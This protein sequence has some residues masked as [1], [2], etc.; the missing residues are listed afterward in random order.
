ML[1]FQGADGRELSR[2]WSWW[3]RTGTTRMNFL[4]REWILD[5]G[6]SEAAFGNYTRSPGERDLEGNWITP[7]TTAWRPIINSTLNYEFEEDTRRLII[8]EACIEP[9]FENSGGVV[10]YVNPE[11]FNEETTL[12]EIELFRRNWFRQNFPNLSDMENNLYSI[13]ALN[14]I[15]GARIDYQLFLAYLNQESWIIKKWEDF[16]TTSDENELPP[17]EEDPLADDNPYD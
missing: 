4:I 1:L 12:E 3:Y 5:C 9:R 13:H 16:S 10:N 11:P 7:P 6:V 15:Q 8:V 14:Y 17:D 2:L